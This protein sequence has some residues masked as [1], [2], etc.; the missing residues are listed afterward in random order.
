MALKY[1]N[2]SLITDSSELLLANGMCVSV[3]V[4]FFLP[5]SASLCPFRPKSHCWRLEQRGLWPC[6]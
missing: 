2:E 5:T 3:W 1:S 4:I 6:I